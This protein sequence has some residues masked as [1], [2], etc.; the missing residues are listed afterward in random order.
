MDQCCGTG[1]VGTVTFCCVERG[2]GT[3]TC[4]KVRTGIGTAISYGSG[5]VIK[6]YHKSSH[7]HTVKSCVFDFL[8]LTFFSF[9]FYN[10]FDETYQFFPCKKILDVKRQDFFQLI[11]PTAFYG[12]DT[13]PEPGP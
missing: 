9:T 7:K 13:E 12:L 3:V 1:T 2:T 8:Q 11:F 6:W 10:K 4:Q 5:P